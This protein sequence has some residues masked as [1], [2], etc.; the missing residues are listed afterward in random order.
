VST[1]NLSDGGQP[2][3]DPVSV[4]IPPPRNFDEACVIAPALT[5]LAMEAGRLSDDDQRGYISIKSRLH[6]IIDRHPALW[7]STDCCHHGVFV[8][9]GRPRRRAR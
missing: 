6:Q 4:I 9:S 5:G 2:A 7:G 1:V 3:P 8:L